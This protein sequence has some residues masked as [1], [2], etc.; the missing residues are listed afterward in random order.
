MDKYIA[1][2]ILA[3][4]LLTLIIVWGILK[5]KTIVRFERRML[6][7]IRYDIRA[8]RRR[9]I[10]RCRKRSQ[11]LDQTARAIENK[12]KKTAKSS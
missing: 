1:I 12:I 2:I 7:R 3:E 9:K 11:K 5:E 6:S 4:I 8:Y 10:A